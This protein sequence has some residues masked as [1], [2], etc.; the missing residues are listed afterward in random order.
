MASNI[1]SF[2]FNE[3]NKYVIN[4]LR[5]GKFDGIL[6]PDFTTGEEIVNKHDEFKSLM[7]TG[8][9]RL[10]LRC[11]WIVENK[12]I[13]ITNLP[14]YTTT[15]TIIK[16]IEKEKIPGIADVR[17]ESDRHGL[18]LTIDCV[19]KKSVDEVMGSLLKY[20]DLQKTVMTNVTVIIDSFPVIVGIQDLIVHWVEFRKKVLI[21]QFNKN[22]QGIEFDIKKNSILVELL[23]DEKIFS[24]F[25]DE[26]KK[27]EN[28]GRDYL[29][30]F[31]QEKFGEA[32]RQ[33]IDWL[34]GLPLRSIANLS[35]KVKSIDSLKASLNEIKYNIQNIE[36]YIAKQLTEINSKVVFDR[37]CSLTDVDY[38]FLDE[39]ESQAVEV[40]TPVYVVVDG[41][42]VKKFADSGNA[43]IAGDYIKC[44]SNDV[45]SFI[46]NQGR[47]LRVYLDQ[48]DY[49]K[50]ATDAGTYLSVYLGVED[51]FEV[52]AWNLVEDKK[53]GYLFNDGFVSVVDYSEWL[54][55]KRRSKITGNGVSAE[56][57]K[58]IYEID[59]DTK[60][61]IVYT[62][63]NR[64]G[65]F[66]T[67]FKHKH[68]EARTRLVPVQK[69]DEIIYVGQATAQDL[70]TTFPQYLKYEGKLLK[71]ADEND[72][73]A[74]RDLVAKG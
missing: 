12:S 36:E 66:E 15:R 48:I 49:A 10:K 43:K 35:N 22:M 24:K 41:K 16:Q 37:S 61:L 7:E 27:N 32:D 58:I 6:I 8:R 18:K 23:K 26:L 51:N 20:T 44:M 73:D 67:D 4:Y 29:T 38:E 40:V 1:P 74:V 45:I 9:C 39:D 53:I 52:I 34:L 69:Y 31:L 17:D 57:G 62:K 54:S 55:T 28:A 33:I 65:V 19:N 68:R 59:M 56:A 63:S 5:T 3:A 14:Y 13:I 25:I 50:T 72:A 64:A 21:R 42:F 46:D 30:A 47:L 71:I 70:I 11:K 2:N 60:Y